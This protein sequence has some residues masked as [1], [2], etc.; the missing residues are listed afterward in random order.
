MRPKSVAALKTNTIY[1]PSTFKHLLPPQRV[2][3]LG[4]LLLSRSNVAGRLTGSVCVLLSSLQSLSTSHILSLA[5][6]FLPLYISTPHLASQLWRCSFSTP[7]LTYRSPLYS[8]LLLPVLASTPL[9][10]T[11]RWQLIDQ[12]ICVPHQFLVSLSEYEH[13][14]AHMNETCTS[15]WKL[16]LRL[17]SILVE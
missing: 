13:C 9:L 17:S 14:T 7:P 2:S 10:E 8:T 6:S 4:T 3:S 11:L 1:K 16:G 15:N 5:L 12:R